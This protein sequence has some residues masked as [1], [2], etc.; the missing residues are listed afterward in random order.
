MTYT[1]TCVAQNNSYRDEIIVWLVDAVTHY[2]TC[3]FMVQTVVAYLGGPTETGVLN[4][5][6][7]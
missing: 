1:I 4:Y 5:Y 6:S 7:S 2:R 3:S